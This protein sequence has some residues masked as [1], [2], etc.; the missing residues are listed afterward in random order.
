M[1]T[2]SIDG[3][4]SGLNTSQIIDQLMALERQPQTRLQQQKAT[5]QSRLDAYTQ[6][7]SKLG[8]LGSAAFDLKFESGWTSRTAVSGDDSVLVATAGPGTLQATLSMQVTRLAASHALVSSG[9]VGAL[10]DRVASG[11]LTIGSTVVSDIGDGSLGSV[12]DAINASGAGVTATAL[13][14][15]PGSFR[16][17]LTSRTT[18]DA[19]VFTA[20]GFD[21]ALGSMDVLSQGQDAQL[22]FGTTNPIVV[23]SATNT[24][25][26]LGDGLT[27]TAKKKTTDPVT[28]DVKPDVD[29]IAAKVQKL[30]DAYNAAASYVSSQSSY[31]ASTKK[32]GVLLGD[33]ASS[34]VMAQLRDAIG[35]ASAGGMTLFDVGFSTDRSGTLSFDKDAF[36]AAY[37]K[38]PTTVKA[39]FQGDGTTTG[40][41]TVVKQVIDDATATGSGRLAGVIDSKQAT[42]RDLTSSIADWDDR[43]ATREAQLRTQFNNLETTLGKLRDQSSWLAGQISSL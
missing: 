15:A 1:A 18:G 12:V 21:P 19:G 37:T 36:V 3:L 35:A 11:P 40:F 7:S 24:F 23:S 6:L 25:T 41:A 20:S 28:V 16:L 32:A 2:S 27:I 42:I 14:V 5:E 4:V 30:V 22:S 33:T 43:L 10:T 9:S 29:A 39:L 31:D 13:Q 34:G 17:Q 38:D 8:A 26:G